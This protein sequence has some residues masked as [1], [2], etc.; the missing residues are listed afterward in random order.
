M[1]VTEFQTEGALTLK[2]L[3]LMTMLTLS[4]MQK[5]TVCWMII[6]CLLVDSCG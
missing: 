1:T 2:A 3:L 6:M 4:E 5:A